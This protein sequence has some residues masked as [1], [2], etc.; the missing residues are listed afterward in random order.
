VPEH[1]FGPLVPRRV[2]VQRYRSLVFGRRLS[3]SL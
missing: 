1:L 2:V 3:S